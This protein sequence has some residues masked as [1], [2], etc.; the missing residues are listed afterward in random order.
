MK[1]K[2]LKV[3]CV[4]GV[5][6]MAFSF[7]GCGSSDSDSNSDKDT[8]KTEAPA[9]KDDDKSESGT[10]EEY[11]NTDE[12][13]SQIDTL[14]QTYSGQGMSIEVKAEDNV[15]IYEYTYESVAKAD[16]TDDQIAELESALEQQASTFE[17][18]ADQLKEET[19]V[20]DPVVRVVYVGS[21]GEVIAQKDFSS[22]N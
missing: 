20:K 19:G 12:F 13:Q 1:K 18:L 21:D 22:S 4:A 6:A 2:L 8:T 14:K 9:N 10:L 3:V 11:V 5:L 16:V 15:L 7:V 17:L